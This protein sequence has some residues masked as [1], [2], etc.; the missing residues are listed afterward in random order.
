MKKKT[1]INYWIDV[2]LLI[3]FVLVFITG[4]VK[5]PSLVRNSGFIRS[6]PLKSLSILH[7]WSG[8]IMGLLVIIHLILHWRWMVMMTKRLLL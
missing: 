4:I 7:D 6:L 3:S 1:V 5:W 2:G 8:L